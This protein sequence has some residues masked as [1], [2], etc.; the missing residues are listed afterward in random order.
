MSH[1]ALHSS[2]VASRGDRGNW[3]A[4]GAIAFA[5]ACGGV[6]VGVI[7]SLAVVMPMVRAEFAAQ[8]KSLDQKLVS[9][10]PVDGL[11]ACVG[12]T[13]PPS[14]QILG[15]SV[16]LPSGG[17]GGVV[18]PPSGTPSG[19]S[20]TFVTKLVKGT[21]Q[22]NVASIENTGPNSENKI[23]ESNQSTTTVTNTN[24]I[25]VSNTNKQ[26]A[27]SGTAAVTENT[28]GGSAT[29]GDASNTN[30]TGLKI[31]VANE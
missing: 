14:A 15:A 31:N 29:S 22:K 20:Q 10:A 1:G 11:N 21:L 30:T 5:A 25:T 28:T 6:A 24:D 17:R 13:A 18:S 12:S 26:D 7:T 8:S 27:A 19:S 3:L 9:V 23:I 2:T 16:T 4:G